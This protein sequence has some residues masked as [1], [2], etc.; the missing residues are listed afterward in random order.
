MNEFTV[1]EFAALERVSV[2]TVWYW[3]Q[4]GAVETRRNPG[5]GIRILDKRSAVSFY[6]LSPTQ[7]SATQ[8]NPSK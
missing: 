3:I 1:K 8:G 4:K 6:D 5:G 7:K 2:R